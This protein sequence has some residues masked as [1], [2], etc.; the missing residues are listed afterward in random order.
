MPGPGNA[1]YADGGALSF[2][3][4]YMMTQVDDVGVW[5]RGPDGVNKRP[6]IIHVGSGGV[7]FSD[8]STQTVA[9]ASSP[10]AMAM[11][12]G[13][14]ASP[15]AANYHIAFMN[16][17]VAGN[18]SPPIDTAYVTPFALNKDQV[19]TA[20]GINL[21][22]TAAQEA[23]VG[24]YSNTSET[25]LTPNALLAE[26]GAISTAVGGIQMATLG[27]AWTVP[28]TGLYWAVVNSNGVAGYQ[29][30]GAT[31]LSIPNPLGTSGASAM[32]ANVALRGGMTYA[33]AFPDPFAITG[34]AL[35]TTATPYAIFQLQ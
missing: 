26:S 27:T 23:R 19:V 1:Q 34:G 17:G 2:V 24:I 29:F 20:L 12:Q 14:A 33:S 18:V 21:F 25:N 32:T 16:I 3:A 35:I 28:E 10:N 22:A 7:V 13:D 30:R 15:A 4:N 11:R 6:N 5:G 31:I 9:A 8:G